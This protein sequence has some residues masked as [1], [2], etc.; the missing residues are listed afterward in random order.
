M[1]ND[2][3]AEYANDDAMGAAEGQKV[4]K[5]YDS[6]D[7][8]TV[9]VQLLLAFIAL[10]SLWFKRQSE[11]PKRKLKTWV[12][13]V[14]KQGLGACYAHVLNMVGLFLIYFVDLFL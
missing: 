5:V 1:A 10:L 4:C 9:F 2:D 13:D 12:L 11:V 8:F 14:S 7:F 3:V 6:E